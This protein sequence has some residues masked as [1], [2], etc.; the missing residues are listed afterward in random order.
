[1]KHPQAKEEIKQSCCCSAAQGPPGAGAGAAGAGPPLV[2]ISGG[3][4]TCRLLHQPG[5]LPWSPNTAEALLN[6]EVQFLR[7]VPSR[8]LLPVA[9][10]G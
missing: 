5:V 6:G 4:W 10:S 8:A 7:L 1:M 3:T 2:G 9:L